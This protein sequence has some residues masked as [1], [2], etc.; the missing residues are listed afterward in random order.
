MTD[1][2]VIRRTWERS[3]SQWLPEYGDHFRA[4]PE[5]DRIAINYQD[6]S[7]VEMTFDLVEFHRKFGFFD[8]RRVMCYIGTYKD[9]TV[10]VAIVDVQTRN[11][12]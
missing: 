11:I 12:M 4:V 9:T 2:E 3:H 8:S 6:V 10:T 5:T 7:P 1:D